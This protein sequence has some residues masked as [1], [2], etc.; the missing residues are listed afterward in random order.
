MAD[1][2]GQDAARGGRGRFSV[3]APRPPGLGALLLSLLLAA[4]AC[5]GP[6]DPDGQT[7]VGPGNGEDPP[8][9]VPHCWD[10]YAPLAHPWT[11]GFDGL[12]SARSDYTPPRYPRT[13]SH[14]APGGD[15]VLTGHL[16]GPTDLAPGATGGEVPAGPA[17][18]F[19]A[20]YAPDG[21]HRFS[22][23]LSPCQVLMASA[24]APD[25][26][27][28][29]F[30]DFGGDQDTFCNLDPT[31]GEDL[32]EN[33]RYVPRLFITRIEPDGTYAWTR[34]NTIEDPPV[35]LSTQ[36]QLYDGGVTA[37]GSLVV[38]ATTG[39]LAIIPEGYDPDYDPEDLIIQGPYVWRLSSEGVGE[40]I[41]R[42]NVIA[43]RRMVVAPSGAVAVTGFQI[44]S[45]NADPTGGMDGFD[46]WT[47]DE[48]G[49]VEGAEVLSVFGSTGDYRFSG[50]LPFPI[51]L[52]DYVFDAD[53]NLY[54]TLT[55][56][57]NVSDGYEDVDPGPTEHLVNRKS[58]GTH[59]VRWNAD[60]TFGWQR[61]SAFSRTNVRL[62]A[63]RDGLY[64]AAG[65]V[66]K[67]DYE[68]G[69][70]HW[71]IL[72]A[73][74]HAHD[75]TADGTGEVVVVGEVNA[76]GAVDVDGNVHPLTRGDTGYTRHLT[77]V[78]DRFEPYP[79]FEGL[80][81]PPCERSCEDLKLDCGIAD[82]G[83][84]GTQDCGVCEAPFTCGGAF[85]PNVCGPPLVEVVTGLNHP[86][87][88][89][90][91]ETHVYYAVRGDITKA[92][93]DPGG[94]ARIERVP[95]DGGPP[96]VLFVGEAN[97]LNMAILGPYLY[98]NDNGLDPISGGLRSPRIMPK[99]GGED[100][101]VAEGPLPISFWP[102]EP[103]ATDAT[104]VYFHNGDITSPALLRAPLDGSGPPSQVSAPCTVP[105]QI[106]DGVMVQLCDGQLYTFP[107]WGGE[108]TVH[109]VDPLMEQAI[110]DDEAFYYVSQAP[111]PVQ[112][113]GIY[114]LPRTAVWESWPPP[115]SELLVDEFPYNTPLVRFGPYFIRGEYGTLTADTLE[116]AIWA[117]APQALTAFALVP[118]INHLASFATDGQTLF[119][120]EEGRLSNRTDTGR[121]LRLDAP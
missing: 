27:V 36:P 111:G 98:F 2:A 80:P 7:P 71:Y 107:L 102:S 119:F 55:F 21:T 121:I 81:P 109:W 120:A 26:A 42:V 65:H 74:Q 89:T 103:H 33:I 79:C 88:V 37:D 115:E 114:R 67:Y 50:M 25:G 58:A 35:S 116:G 75:L 18:P 16:V 101:D 90:A 92:E 113:L 39:S 14:L 20:R 112:H 11:L 6:R 10:G 85:T 56:A 41:Q 43:G 53:E 73:F 23:V 13:R 64:L 54:L 77:R 1:G 3:T 87:V 34:T 83:C 51:E 94:H 47:N 86:N 99:D 4:T 19:V 96:E 78:T 69:S 44:G 63:G 66:Y 17:R 22:H 40:S 95:R 38:Y 12:E 104:H 108:P 32:H 91:D 84:G 105:G 76:D 62:A 70:W 106:R 24:V 15:V 117:Y 68:D 72:D 9:V 60:G 29:L 45:W 5:G 100:V 46:F 61:P 28:I 48:S 52:R 118:G 59:L 8:P 97:V 93:V 82:D 30:G 110:F 31:G 49:A 57:R